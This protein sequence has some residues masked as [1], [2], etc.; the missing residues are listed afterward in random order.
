M[1]CYTDT[2]HVLPCVTLQYQH[3][4][5]GASL[6]IVLMPHIVHQIVSG[7]VIAR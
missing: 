5:T 3:L 7:S 2:I 4:R 1:L 6:L